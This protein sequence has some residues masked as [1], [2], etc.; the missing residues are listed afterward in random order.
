MY[1]IHFA[2]VMFNILTLCLIL[3]EIH[4]IFVSFCAVKCEI[5][6]VGKKK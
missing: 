1:N 6:I 2:A 3:Q 4:L 5:S